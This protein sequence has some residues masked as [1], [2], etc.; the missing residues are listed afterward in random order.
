MLCDGRHKR[1]FQG[2]TRFQGIWRDDTGSPYA[3]RIMKS[4]RTKPTKLERSAKAAIVPGH[5]MQE[6][7]AVTRMPDDDREWL[8]TPAT[9]PATYVDYYEGG[10][11]PDLGLVRI[12]FGESAGSS[13]TA[14]TASCHV[15]EYVPRANFDAIESSVSPSSRCS[16]KRCASSR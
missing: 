2:I 16:F 9:Y 1:A 15:A 11:L 14:I 13:R 5:S 7:F 4:R 6:G 10:Y 3:G 12:A 8:R